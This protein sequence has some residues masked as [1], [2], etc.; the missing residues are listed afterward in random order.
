MRLVKID[1]IYINPELV[2]AVSGPKLN[3]KTWIWVAGGCA[4]EE[5]LYFEVMLPIGDVVDL[6]T[7]GSL[8]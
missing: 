1:N 2:T 8:D 3:D 4:E 7:L 5:G 6:L